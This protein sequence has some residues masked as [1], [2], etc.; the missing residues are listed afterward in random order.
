VGAL[1][2]KNLS[3]L[4][5]WKLEGCTDCAAPDSESCP[6]LEAAVPCGEPARARAY[7]RKAEILDKSTWQLAM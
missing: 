2:A 6:Q 1:E 7:A 4:S 3:L 5:E